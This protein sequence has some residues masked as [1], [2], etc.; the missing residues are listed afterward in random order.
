MEKHYT[1]LLL[2]N[3]LTIAS[4]VAG[5]FVFTTNWLILD[6]SSGS[7][8]YTLIEFQKAG[9]SAVKYHD[10]LESIGDIVKHCN[11]SKECLKETYLIDTMYS[12]FKVV[13]FVLC[14]LSINFLVSGLKIYLYTIR[15]FSS[16]LWYLT[17]M[18][19]FL[20]LTCSSIL[21][22]F[23][24]LIIWLRCKNIK[25]SLLHDYSLKTGFWLA[26]GIGSVISLSGFMLLREKE[27]Y[28]RYINSNEI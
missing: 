4:L 23:L 10:F 2:F 13:I 8:T 20:L 17:N 1:L 14:L 6:E 25:D 15:Y 21:V 5:Y 18:F 22:F 27:L 24:N 26:F 3:I 11:G 28:K 7:T 12:S 19:S 9:A 16:S